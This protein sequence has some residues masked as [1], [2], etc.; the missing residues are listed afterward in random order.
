VLTSTLYAFI[1]HLTWRPRVPHPRFRPKVVHLPPLRCRR[2]S[3][4]VVDDRPAQTLKS[5]I[6]CAIICET[7]SAG[8]S[9]IL[10]GH[11]LP[12]MVP[13]IF[14]ERLPSPQLL[15][16]CWREFPLDF[17]DFPPALAVVV[18]K[19]TQTKLLVAEFYTSHQPF[20]GKLHIFKSMLVAKSS[21]GAIQ[22]KHSH[23]HPVIFLSCN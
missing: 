4:T 11:W 3:I 6:W 13:A 20:L 1:S 21:K 18:L 2:P 8:A 15:P 22:T 7:S 16:E 23:S 12:L 14:V 9:P 10:S 17:E 5:S 19:S